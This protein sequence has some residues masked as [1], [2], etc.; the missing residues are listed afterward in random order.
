LTN[1]YRRIG[2]EHTDFS[3]EKLYEKMSSLKS[4]K[5]GRIDLSKYYGKIKRT[6]TDGENITCTEDIF[7]YN[8]DLCAYQKLTRIE[9]NGNKV[10]TY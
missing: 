10:T 9:Q 5:F 6:N 3:Y 2:C 1:E 8:L 4:D 7:R